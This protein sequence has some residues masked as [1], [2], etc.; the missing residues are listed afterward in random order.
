M[1]LWLMAGRDFQ[2]TQQFSL[3]AASANV[4]L[5]EKIFFRAVKRDAKVKV[6][7]IPLVIAQ[8]GAEVGRTT[9][10]AAD[11]GAPDKLTAEF[12]PAKAGKY[13]A[14]AKFPD[15]TSQTARFIV[16]DE[17][18]EQTEVATDTGYLKK[19]CESS[20]GHLLKPEEVGSFLAELRDERSV[21][22][23]QTKLTSA[24]DRVWIFWLIGLLFAADWYL[25]R[26]WG[27]C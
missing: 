27:L 5:G 26:R 9:L 19:L 20:G 18:L 2:P 11:A 6:A 23:P 1:I 7:S 17:N 25:R 8:N 12:V 4:P 3:R 22:T 24:W 10:A 21:E 13:E 15:G 14:T 16:Y